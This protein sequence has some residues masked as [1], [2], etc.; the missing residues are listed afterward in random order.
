MNA[1]MSFQEIGRALGVSK[2]AVWVTYSNAM[3]KIRRHFVREVRAEVFQSNPITQTLDGK[4][5]GWILRRV[6]LHMRCEAFLAEKRGDHAWAT[7][8]RQLGIRVRR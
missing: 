3:V 8:N 2:Q 1:E 7:A 4:S 6:R 5:P